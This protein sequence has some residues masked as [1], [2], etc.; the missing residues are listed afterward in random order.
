MS[1][2]SRDF[3]LTQNKHQTRDN[4]CWYKYQLSVAKP[5]DTRSIMTNM[6]QTKVDAQW[7]KLVRCFALFAS[8]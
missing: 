1:W 7:D 2:K 4:N 3:I 8:W 5:R 6:L